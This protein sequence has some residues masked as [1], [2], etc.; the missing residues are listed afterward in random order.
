M[1]FTFWT[2]FQASTSFFFLRRFLTKQRGLNVTLPKLPLIVYW[3]THN[4]KN[5]L[6]GAGPIKNE[7]QACSAN[8]ISS[9][10]ALDRKKITK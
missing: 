7:Y 10:F 1:K 2:S 9:N 3:R 4:T 6:N 8:M 5:V